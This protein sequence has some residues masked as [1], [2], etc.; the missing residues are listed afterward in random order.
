MALTHQNIVDYFE[1]KKNGTYKCPFCGKE[2]FHT[3]SDLQGN[4]A[5]IM[6]PMAGAPLPGPAHS[7][8]SIICSNCGRLDLFHTWF[9]EKWL[10]D[11]G[12]AQA[13]EAKNG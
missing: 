8:C 2:S 11:R 9:V 7:V 4:L 10:V 1:A 3:L 6:M 5:I 13:P 12:P